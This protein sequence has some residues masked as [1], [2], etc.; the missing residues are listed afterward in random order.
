MVSPN[1]FFGRDFSVCDQSEHL[2]ECEL[3]FGVINL[4]AKQS[5]A[6]AILLSIVDQLECVVSCA[7]APSENSDDQIG[8]VLSQF[9]H[10][11][12]SVIDNF[13]KEWPTRLRN[14]CQTSNNVVVDEFAK[15]IRRYSAVNVGIE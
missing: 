8:I 1:S 7:R 10:G 5:N 4:P 2:D 11:S 15:F 3:M 13:E 14:T 9:F 12:R 6:G